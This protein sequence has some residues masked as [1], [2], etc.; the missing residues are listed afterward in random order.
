MLERCLA[1]ACL[2]V[3]SALTLTACGG[4]KSDESQ[5]EEAVETSA[6]STDPADCKKFSTQHFM[7]QTTKSIGSEA[8]ESCE[9]Q[10]SKSEGVETA[11]VSSVEIDGSEATADAALGG[12]TFDGQEVEV[13]LVKDGDQWKLNEIA[14]FTKFDPSKVIEAFEKEFSEPSSEVSKSQAAC[15]TGAFEKAAKGEFEAALL[16]PSTDGFEEIAGSCF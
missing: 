8:V 15:V 13:A 6:T 4:G 7:E 3:V 1:L 16:S 9:E 2:L 12:G 10:A 14:G 5:I 11:T